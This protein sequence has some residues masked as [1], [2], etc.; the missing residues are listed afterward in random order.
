VKINDI[1]IWQFLGLESLDL[2]L[3]ALINVEESDAFRDQAAG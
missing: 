1:T 3:Q 2:H